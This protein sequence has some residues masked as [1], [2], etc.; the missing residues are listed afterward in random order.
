MEAILES[1]ADHLVGWIVAG[2]LT[3]VSGWL[4]AIRSRLSIKKQFEAQDERIR[5][6]FEGAGFLVPAQIDTDE[7]MDVV[8]LRRLLPALQ[9][10]A[11]YGTHENSKRM[12]R[13]R[14]YLGLKLNSLSIPVP[15]GTELDLWFVFCLMMV[16]YAEDGR[17][18]DARTLLSSLRTIDPEDV[19][20]VGQDAL[21][22]QF[23]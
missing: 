3:A 6:L 9:T 4:W 5:R 14:I 19:K 16:P 23:S 17:L 18:E 1:I 22:G 8:R 7:D 21:A 20:A 11:M 13:E 15:T 10:Y 2:T 12:Q